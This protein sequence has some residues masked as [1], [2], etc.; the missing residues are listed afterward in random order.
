MLHL[1]RGNP[2]HKYRLCEELIESSPTEKD[3]GVLVD[4]K[5]DTS[6]QCVLVAQK[7]N[8]ILGCINRGVS[9][10]SRQVIVPLCF[11]LVRPHLECCIQIWGP[12]HEKDVDLLE[13]VQRMAKKMI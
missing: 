12:Q 6:Q 9:S 3:L 10:R 2:R 4:E 7:T 13:Q 5:L 11:A 1:G 8:R